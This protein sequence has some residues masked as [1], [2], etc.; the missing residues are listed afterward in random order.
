MANI[1]G[2]PFDPYVSKQIIDRQ[3]IHGSAQR[4][5]SILSYLNSRTSYIKLTSGVKV[6]DYERLTRI[7]LGGHPSFGDTGLAERFV[8]FNGTSDKNNTLFG[9]INGLDPKEPNIDIGQ[10]IL[11]QHAYGL[12]GNEFGIRPMPGVKSCDIKSRNRGSIREANIQIKVWNR[13]QFEIINLLYLRLGFPMLLEWGHTIIVDADGNINPNPN[14]S[15]SSDF[16]SKKYKTD[17]DVL[18]AIE[19]QRKLSAG[20]Y[21]AM[22]G[23]VVNFDWSFNKDGSYD[24]TLKLISIGA[25]IESLKINCYL[26]DLSLTTPVN[27][28][29]DENPESDEEWIDKFKFSHSIGYI[30]W[31]A[32]YALNG[33]VVGKNDS[34]STDK[35]DGINKNELKNFLR[36]PQDFEVD[37]EFIKSQNE[38]I[39]T[40]ITSLNTPSTDKDYILYGLDGFDELF[41]VRFGEFLRLLQILIPVNS[42]SSTRVMS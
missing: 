8:L 11:N 35:I 16:L 4:T 18:K 2:E 25:V 14:F 39:N 27:T 21:D 36:L 22:Y 6:L 17:N 10:T 5:N 13:N 23:K 37:K 30:F 32:M 31:A 1:V 19:S 3:K 9:G 12:G 40:Y 38:S 42:D 24:V 33:F 41:Y 20:N 28:D 7:D 34:F 26:K 15:L 29:T